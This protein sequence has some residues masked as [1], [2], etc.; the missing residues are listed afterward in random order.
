M[1]DCVASVTRLLASDGLEMIRKASFVA[2]LKYSPSN[3]MAGQRKATRGIRAAGAP[4]GART[5][6]LQN[7]GTGF[8]FLTPYMPLI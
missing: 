7:Q 2:P 4:S 5:R 1:S 8:H 6:T 3:F